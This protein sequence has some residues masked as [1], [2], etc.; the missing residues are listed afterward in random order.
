MDFKRK[1]EIHIVFSGIIKLNKN[2]ES[3]VNAETSI[4]A[5]SFLLF[6]DMNRDFIEFNILIYV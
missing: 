3:S 1:I 5:F 4:T 6:P 2:N